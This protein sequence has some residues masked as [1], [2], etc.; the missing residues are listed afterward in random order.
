MV[1]TEDIL[2][3]HLIESLYVNY[4]K[5]QC[6]SYINYSNQ[7]LVGLIHHLY[8]DHSTI[9]PMDKEK[10]EKKM[11]QEQ[12]LLDPMVDLFRK[13]E[14]GLEFSEASNTPIPGVG[15][16]QHFLPAYPQDRRNVKIL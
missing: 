7:T 5:G 3:Q 11:K 2:K 14:E 16:C 9:T 6:Q 1:N 8:D 13:F 10:S 15:S 4:F 12:A